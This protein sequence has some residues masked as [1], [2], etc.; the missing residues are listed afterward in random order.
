MNIFREIISDVLFLFAV[1]VVFGMAIVF[2]WYGCKLIYDTARH[3]NTSHDMKGWLKKNLKGILICLIVLAV[4]LGVYSY[5]HW[6][7]PY[8]DLKHGF[9]VVNGFDCPDNYPIK[10]HLGSMIYHLPGDPYYNRTSAS[11]GDCFD[12]A[13]DAERQGF[14]AILR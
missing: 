3:L 13:Q 11:N 10:A 12:T 6:Y 5:Y 8:W 14:R 2:V 4:F 1:Y 9:V 7:V